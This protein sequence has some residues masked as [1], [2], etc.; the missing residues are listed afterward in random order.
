MSLISPVLQGKGEQRM[1]CSF[2]KIRQA[3]LVDFNPKISILIH[4]TYTN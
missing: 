1:K 2:L 3:G 4:P